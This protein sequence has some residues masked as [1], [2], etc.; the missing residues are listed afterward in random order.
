[1]EPIVG[2]VGPFLIYGYTV[3]LAGSIALALAL[4]RALARRVPQFAGLP[5]W[6]DGVLAALLG[7]LLGGR[8]AFVVVEWAYFAQ[9]P[10][11]IW[12]IGQ[13]G[14]GYHGALLGGIIGLWLWTVVGKRPFAA[15]LNL[16]ASAFALVNVGGWYAC[17]L[18]GCAYGRETRY[19]SQWWRDWLAGDL[20]DTF[21]LFALRYQTQFLGI[22]LGLVALLLILYAIKRGRAHVAFPLALLTI[23]LGHFLVS[24]VRDDPMPV[25]ARVRLD[26]WVSALLA[27]FAVIQYRWQRQSAPSVVGQLTNAQ[28]KQPKT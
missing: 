14:F 26:T 16:L 10:S 6:V 1:M 25:F 24:L 27:T 28:P 4:T 23:S 9:R 15:Y 17:W 2:R 12:R 19:T 20:P 13:G 5:G 11:L 3:A 22:I 18:H 7:A 21:G 8:A